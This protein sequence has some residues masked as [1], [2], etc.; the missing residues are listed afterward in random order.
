[1]E[2]GQAILCENLTVLYIASVLRLDN[3]VDV[4]LSLEF[5][6]SDFLKLKHPDQKMIKSNIVIISFL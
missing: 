1:M 6:V 4:Q 5:S 2:K 3:S